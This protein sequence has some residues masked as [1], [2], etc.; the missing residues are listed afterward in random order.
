[1]QKGYIERFNRSFREDMLDAYMFTLLIQFL[2]W[3]TNGR[4]DLSQ[5][6]A[7]SRQNQKDPVNCK[8]FL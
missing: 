3:N 2:A 5:M 6:E 7:V 8:R 4:F 1:M